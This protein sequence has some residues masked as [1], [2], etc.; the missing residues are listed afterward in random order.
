MKRKIFMTAWDMDIEKGGINKVM[1]KR[2]SLFAN[3]EYDIELLTMDF[4]F[5]YDIIEKELKLSGQLPKSAKITN[6]YDYYRR[7]FTKNTISSAAQA[8]FEQQIKKFEEGY[9][10]EDGGEFARYFQNGTYIKYKKWHE[11][12]TIN[13]IDYFDDNRVRT[14]REEFHHTGFLQREVLYHPSNNKKNQERFYTEDGFCFLSLW[15]NNKSGKLQKVYLFSPD[16]DKVEYFPSSK[17]FHDFWLNEICRVEVVKP[18]IICDGSAPTTRV[19]SIDDELVYKIYMLHSNHFSAPYELGSPYRTV[20][21]AKLDVIPKGYPVVVLTEQQ[22]LDL[23]KEI[24]NRGNIHVIP[25]CVEVNDFNIEKN[26]KLVSMI[27]RYSPEK[28]LD[29]A[30]KAFSLVVEQ[31]PEAKL[32][33]YGN[34][35]EEESLN[36][37][38]QEL[39]LENSVELKG[40]TNK[41]HEVLAASSVSLVTSAYEGFSLA[42]LESLANKTPVISY[43]INYGPSQVIEDGVN[44]YLVPNG[45]SE[46]LAE[47]IIHLLNNHDLVV[48]MGNEARNT[49]LKDYSPERYY[50]KWSK[51]LQDVV[52][53]NH[54]LYTQEI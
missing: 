25:N 1:L 46:Q 52:N 30:I 17:E 8:K 6:V 15:Y 16:Y 40:Y 7:K 3:D 36:K 53:E 24:G 44:G 39:K 54:N 11:D 18:V 45:D 31:V 13:F 14:R 27:A 5:N 48:K 42:M 29:E 37:L 49:V 28:R 19:T 12:G 35:N 21:Q 34:G 22:R 50:E 4:K 38:I 43:D 2:A 23:H 26:P 9:W 33:I 10:V 32:D 47:K 51:L 20:Y 41:V